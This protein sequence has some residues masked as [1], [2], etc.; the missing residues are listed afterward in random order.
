LHLQA[1]RL[2][3]LRHDAESFTNHMDNAISYSEQI[4]DQED[5][6]VTTFIGDLTSI[7]ETSIVPKVP[8]L[9]SS[10]SL[11]TKIDSKR[12]TE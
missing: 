9:G 2:S 6:R 12:G 7:R 4:F 5:D 10:L 8:A 11:F 1:S 3:A